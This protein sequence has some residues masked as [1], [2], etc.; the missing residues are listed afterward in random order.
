MGLEISGRSIDF[1]FRGQLD[2]SSNPNYPT[3]NMGDSYEV[4]VAGKIGGASGTI[5]NIGDELRCMVNGSAAGTQAAVGANWNIIQANLPITTDANS[6]ILFSATAPGTNAAKVHVI[7]EGTAPT[8]RPADAVQVWVGQYAPGD[9]R[10]YI[11]G[12]GTVDPVIIG[13]GTVIEGTTATG[14]G[15]PVRQDSGTLTGTPLT[16]APSDNDSS[17]QIAT[18]AFAKSQDAVLRREPDQA[19]HMTAAASGSSGITV[20]DNDNIDFGTG[21]FTLVWKGSLPDWTPAADVILLQKITVG[22]GFQLDLLTTGYLEL[23]LNALTFATTSAVSAI[24]GTGHEI[25]VTVSVGATQTTVSFY[26]DGVLLQAPAAQNNTTT[27]SSAA[28]FYAMGTSA[29]RTAG[30]AS[31]VATY[32]RA[33]TAAEVLDLYRNGVDFA[34]MWGSQTTKVVNGTFDSD[35]SSWTA[36]RATLA[37]VVGGESGNCLE[38]TLTSGSDQGA[39]QNIVTVV[40]KKYRVRGAIKS[41]TSGN[42]SYRIAATDAF[43]GAGSEYVAL[44]GTTSGS[45]VFVSG[46]FTATTIECSVRMYKISA[47]AG[48]MLFD[49]ISLVEIGATLLL[50]PEGITKSGWYGQANGLNASYPA[51]GWSLT[52]PTIDI[53]DGPILLSATTVAFNANA[54]TTLYTVPTG[55]RCVLSHAVAV[56]GADA[57]ATTTLAIGQDTA[58]TDF[59]GASTLSNLDAQYDAVILM[60]VPNATPV[61]VKSYAAGTVIQAQVGSQSGGATN[62]VYLFGFL[63]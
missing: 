56:A 33:L 2:C 24:D 17:T 58:E 6:N 4:S 9:D 18:T 60:P 54:D 16:S 13:G 14:T 63:Y 7:T 27:V 30:T 20:A 26:V 10:L 47:T 55:R 50:P 39:W 49:T 51:T 61:K 21:N 59:V 19:V 34:D 29:V 22:V 36:I 38:V 15:A 28:V 44:E 23:T 12:E 43:S 32:N 1:V 41:G 52:R 62:T 57:G 37:S 3:A 5:V 25:M 40:G 8:T 42:E 53:G 48:T 11:L 46:E 45:W 35:A 31:F